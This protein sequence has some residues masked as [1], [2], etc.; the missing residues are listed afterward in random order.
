MR[1]PIHDGTKLIPKANNDLGCL[2][3]VVICQRE[4]TCGVEN[5]VA[6][7]QEKA[8][9]LFLFHFRAVSAGPN[10]GVSFSLLFS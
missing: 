6:T 3:S 8:L 1:P 10:S 7:T 2:G 5:Y 4:R 9:A